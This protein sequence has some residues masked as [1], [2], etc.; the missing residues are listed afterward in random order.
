MEFCQFSRA[1]DMNDK[2]E[3]TWKVGID[4]GSSFTDVLTINVIDGHQCHRL[5]NLSRIALVVT[6][7]FSDTSEMSL[8][9]REFERTNRLIREA[10]K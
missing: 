2:N 7:G 10:A 4:I 8:E 5:S 9:P 1:G 3:C 6:E